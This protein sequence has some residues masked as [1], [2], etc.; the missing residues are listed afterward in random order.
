MQ[1]GERAHFR[2]SEQDCQWIGR[3]VPQYIAWY[4]RAS[5]H[6]QIQT[7]RVNDVQ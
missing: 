3:T 5:G 7:M 4:P 6:K 2:Y 1:A